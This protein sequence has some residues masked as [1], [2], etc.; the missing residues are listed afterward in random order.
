MYAAGE[1]RSRVA[2]RLGTRNKV[3][4]AVPMLNS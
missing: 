2:D 3:P 4:C 1:P